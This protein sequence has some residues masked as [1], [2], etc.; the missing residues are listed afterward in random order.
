MFDYLNEALFGWYPYFCAGVFVLGSFLRFEREQFTWR[1]G[2]SQLFRRRQLMWGSNLFHVGILF[3]F[4]GHFVGLLTPHAVYEL[5]ISAEAKQLVAIYAGSVAGVITFVGLTLL[6]HRRL[7]D[8]RVRVT[9]QFADMAILVILWVQLLL[10]LITVPFSLAHHD[11]SV[12]LRLAEW[13]QRIVTGQGDAAVLIQGL[14]WPYQ[15]HLVL[16]M[17]IFLLFPFSRLVHVWSAPIWFLGRRGWQIVRVRRHE[18]RY[19]A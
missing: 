7:F 17:T 6:L 1:S 3:L 19:P 10:G 5:V 2:S 13:S 11:A 8:A 9:T 12:M 18:D 4:F 14:A 16:G 15:A